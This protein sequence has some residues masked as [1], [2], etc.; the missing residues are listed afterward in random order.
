M[1]GRTFFPLEKAIIRYMLNFGMT[2]FSKLTKQA[3]ALPQKDRAHIARLIA[4]SLDMPAEGLSPKEWDRLWK[5]KLKNRAE[6]RS[7]K[8]KTAPA[9][10]VWAKLKAKQG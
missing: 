7:G 8:I 10:R 6:V 1:S 3:L 9:D 5:I 4:K 2:D